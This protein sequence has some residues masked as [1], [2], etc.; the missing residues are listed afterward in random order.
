M[1]EVPAVNETKYYP[2]SSIQRGLAFLFRFYPDLHILNLAARLDFEEEIDEELMLRAIRETE[3][4]VAFLKV[5]L[6]MQDAETM[7]QYLYEGEP[8]PVEVVDLS[9]RTDEEIA[10]I[11]YDWTYDAFPNSILD[12]QL[13]SFKLVRCPNGKRSLY[14]CVEH[15]IIDGFCTLF[16]LDYLDRVYAALATGTELPEPTEAPWKLVESDLA[17]AASEKYQKQLLKAEAEFETEPMFTSI[18][19]LGAPEFIEGKRYGK[20]M[21]I[22]KLDGG[23]IRLPIPAALAARVDESAKQLNI[24]PSNYYFLALRSYLG[25]VSGTDDV[26]ICTSIAASRITKYEKGAG[27]DCATQQLVR[28]IIPFETGFEDALLQLSVTQ[29]DMLRHARS[30]SVD[31]SKW[32]HERYDVPFGCEYYTMQYSYLPLYGLSDKYL[33]FTPSYVSNGQSNQPCYMLILPGDRS[34]TLS[35]TYV[36]SLADTKPESIERYHRFMLAFLEAGMD[37][38]DRTIRE[39]IDRSL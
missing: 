31:L 24:S 26:T 21:D 38:P 30:R 9:D 29:N 11:M 25:H 23:C 2:L 37:G 13:Y 27:L 4:R 32:L 17:F 15:F 18:N 39:L 6:H 12:E 22:S 19:G 28:S 16:L 3:S 10:R 1:S 7:V 34:G 8:T 20:T 33:K 35:T 5:R 14:V 36:Y